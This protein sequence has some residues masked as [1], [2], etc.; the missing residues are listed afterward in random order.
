MIT[1][2]PPQRKLGLKG[3]LEMIG[4]HSFQILFCEALEFCTDA[5]I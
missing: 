1:E 3:N 5:Q 4:T 2:K